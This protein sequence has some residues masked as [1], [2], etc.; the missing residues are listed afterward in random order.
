MTLSVTVLAI[1]SAT[2]ACSAALWRNGALAAHAFTRRRHGHAEILL[3][4][5]RDVME[6]ARQAFATLDLIA[7]TVGPGSF[8]GLRIGLS[9]ARAL[10]L[11]AGKPIIGL[12]TLEVVAAAQPA[13]GDPLLVAID[14]R[15]EDIFVQL[16]S[17]DL[18]PLCPP[19]AMLAADIK[20]ILPAGAIAIAGNAAD[21]VRRAVPSRDLRPAGGPALPDAGI[22]ARCAASR[23]PGLS[24]DEPAPGPLYLRPP[25]AMLPTRAGL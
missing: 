15:R 3:P 20:S 6:Q 7:T 22:L 23:F 13:T 5:I 25:D 21:A 14:S 2:D 8:T 16:F 24:G 11:A 17:S 1:D 18:S 4:M 19:A 10:A 9:S 12:T